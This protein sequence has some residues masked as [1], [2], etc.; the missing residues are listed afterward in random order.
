MH[1]QSGR[2]VSIVG[3]SAWGVWACVGRATV[4]AAR[5][6]AEKIPWTVVDMLAATAPGWQRQA[7]A[8]GAESSGLRLGEARLGGDG[9][10]GRSPAS[11]H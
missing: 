10:V 1:G 6:R 5:G 11:A 2:V 4:R 9:A 3:Q 8:C 7:P